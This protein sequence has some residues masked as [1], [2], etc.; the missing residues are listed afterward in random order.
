MRAAVRK[1][2]LT[3][4]AGVCLAGPIAAAAL[5]LAPAAWRKPPL[6][7]GILVAAIALVAWLRRSRP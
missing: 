1:S 2:L 5:G 7:W 6:A 3:L 4:A